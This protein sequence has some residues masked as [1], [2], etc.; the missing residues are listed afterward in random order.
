MNNWN[1][2]KTWRK[3]QRE[4]LVAARMALRDDL[5]KFRNDEITTRLEASF[6]WPVGT[7]IGFCW[8]YKKEFDARFLM[9]KWRDQGAIN[10]LPEVVGKARPLQFRQ[11]RPGVKMAPGVYGIPV[12][13]NTEVLLPDAA[14]VPMNGIDEA[15]YRLGYGGSHT[16][17]RWISS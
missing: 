6:V 14:I 10:A 9:R 12:P 8:P 7:V 11:W 5:H 16:T 15:G 3:M 2:I 1:D 17:F 13:V 4:K